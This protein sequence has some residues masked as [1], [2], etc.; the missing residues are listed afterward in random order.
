M[1]E[2]TV[3]REYCSCGARNKSRQEVADVDEVDGVRGAQLWDGGDSRSKSI[4]MEVTQEA[5]NLNEVGG[6]GRVQH[7]ERTGDGC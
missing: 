3:I 6:G 4:R 1:L 7:G 2:G 5:E